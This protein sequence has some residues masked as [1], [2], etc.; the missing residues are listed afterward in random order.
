MRT[1]SEQRRLNLA[2]PWNPKGRPLR[3]PPFRLVSRLISAA[4]A[5]ARVRLQQADPGALRVADDREPAA[6]IVLR[7]DHLLGPELER[8]AVRGID[9]IDAEVDLPVIRH[10]RGQAALGLPGAGD[11][12]AVELELDVRRL[13]IAH[14]RLL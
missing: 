12:L 8:L 13:A 1:V 7:L 14:R 11:I 4:C 10:A 2:R 5:S 6:R 9:V 3:R